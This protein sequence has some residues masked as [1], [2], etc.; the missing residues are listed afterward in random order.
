[1]EKIIGFIPARGGSKRI[2]YKNMRLLGGKPLVAYTIEAARASDLFT[3][4]VV[5]SDDHPI[6]D[7]ALKMGVRA[8][9][10]PVRLCGDFVQSF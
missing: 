9:R 4:I 2:P 5:S 8:D 3:D 10:R 7:L 1:M 6:L